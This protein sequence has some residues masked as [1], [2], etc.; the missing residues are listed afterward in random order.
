MHLGIYCSTLNQSEDHLVWSVTW[1]K[2]ISALYCL[3]LGTVPTLLK[4]LLTGN[5]AK[6]S[7]KTYKPQKNL[8]QTATLLNRAYAL[9]NIPH[10]VVN[11]TWLPLS[12]Q[13]QQDERRPCGTCGSREVQYKLFISLVLMLK[14]FSAK[15]NIFTYLSLMS[16]CACAGTG[17]AW[18]SGP[19]VWI[20]LKFKHTFR[21]SYFSYYCSILLSLFPLPILNLN[22]QVWYLIVSIPDLCT[23]TYFTLL[24]FTL[25][26][27][28]L[29]IWSY[30]T[31]R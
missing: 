12:I 19:N 29:N 24:Y 25:N 8:F 13:L 27:S 22:I 6:A 16:E 14:C 26:V 21:L 4:K 15:F 20:F 11:N 7:T 18:F 5:K 17:H 9:L 23:L 30:L 10:N 2:I 1:L 28:G 31:V 3:N